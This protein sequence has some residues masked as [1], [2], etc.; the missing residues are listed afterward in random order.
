MSAE[1]SPPSLSSSSSC[2]CDQCSALCCRYFALPLDNPTTVRDYDN[3]RWYLCHENVVVF[4]EK[5]QWYIGIMSRCKQL[6]PDN[7]CGIYQTRPRVCRE[8]TTDTCDYHGGDY[9]FEHLFTSAE[10]LRDYAEKKLNARRN[11]NGHSRVNGSGNGNV[12]RNGNGNGS[13]GN[14]HA[15]RR[16]AVQRRYISL[17]PKPPAPPKLRKHVNGNGHV[18]GVSLPVLA[19]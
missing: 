8:Y 4:V 18:L 3:I 14:G 13:N 17:I 1:S 19:R 11:S 6:Q 10:Q 15:R 5:R 7:R 9:Q 12:N 16:A 2:L